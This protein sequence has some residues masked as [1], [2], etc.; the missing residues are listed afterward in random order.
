MHENTP[1]RS[2]PRCEFWFE[3]TEKKAYSTISQQQYCSRSLSSASY[4]YCTGYEKTF[5]EANYF[6]F[7]YHLRKINPKQNKDP[8]PAL[9]QPHQ[10]Q[11]Y[12]RFQTG[13]IYPFPWIML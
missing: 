9:L 1:E 13:W 5:L 10:K 4:C 2:E 8:G 12:H 6:N 7:L 11:W 3:G